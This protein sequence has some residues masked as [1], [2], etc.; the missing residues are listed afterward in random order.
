MLEQ[1]FHTP[2]RRPLALTNTASLD[3]TQT[4]FLQRSVVAA[5]RIE[6]HSWPHVSLAGHRL[7]GDHPAGGHLPRAMFHLA[8]PGYLLLLLLL[9]PLVWLHL[10]QRGRAVPHPSL[11]LFAGLPVGQSRLARYGGLRCPSEV[12]ALT[13]A[14]VDWER[15]RFLVKAP[16]TAHHADGRSRVGAGRAPSGGRAGRLADADPLAEGRRPGP[17]R[18]PVI[19]ARLRRLRGAVGRGRVPVAGARSR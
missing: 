5:R 7:S 8:S 2:L 14:D 10:R 19:A 4:M 6:V 13:W 3:D 17:D 15:G 16:K 9:P 1:T 12:V 11:G 18:R